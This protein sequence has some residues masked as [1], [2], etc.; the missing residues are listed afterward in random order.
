MVRKSH[1]GFGQEMLYISIVFGGHTFIA[2]N[3]NG[4]FT[5][6]EQLYHGNEI[7]MQCDK[8]LFAEFWNAPGLETVIQVKIYEEDYDETRT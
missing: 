6:L 4:R 5:D 8:L 7:G 3:T 1:H 2:S